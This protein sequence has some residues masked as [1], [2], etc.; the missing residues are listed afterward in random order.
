[1]RS[2][3]VSFGR[4]QITAGFVFLCCAVCLLPP[5]QLLLV[6]VAAVVV[7]ECGHAAVIRLCGGKIQR[8]RLTAFG[9][10]LISHTALFS[11]P[12]DLAVHASGPFAGLLAAV[13]SALIARVTHNEAFYVFAGAN[14]VLSAFNLLPVNSLDGGGCVRALSM[15]Y[16]GREA[17]AVKVLHFIALAVIASLAVVAFVYGGFNV[18]LLWT[19]VWLA[20]KRDS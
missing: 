14:L 5:A 18:A 11:Y 4:L 19:S 10:E 16:F 8:V 1:M 20:V 9:I 12:K 17:V 6:F 2:G 7:H 13:V 3:A 15:M